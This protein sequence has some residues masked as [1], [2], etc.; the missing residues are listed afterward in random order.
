MPP[1]RIDVHHH[2][3]PPPYVEAVGE[4]AIGAL[5]V[6]GRAPQWTPQASVEAMDRNGIATAVTSMSAPAFG[7]G[8]GARKLARQCNDYAAA[9]RRDHPGRFGV[10]ATLPLPDI[11][12]SLAEI[13]Y[14]FDELKADGIGLLTN[15]DGLYPGDPAIAPVFEELDRRGAVVFFHPAAAEPCNCLCGMPAAT[16]DFPFD[17]TRAVA[18]LLL[19]GTFARH[20]NI[21]FVFSHAGGTVPFLAGRL[22]RLERRP[23]YRPQLPDGVMAELKR[24]YFDTALSANRFAFA[25]LLQLTTVEQVLFGSDYPFAPEDTMTATVAGLAGLGL[26]TAELAAIERDNALRLLPGL[27]AA[28][29]APALSLPPLAGGGAG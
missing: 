18:S 27:A 12:G 10:F 11:D 21:R 3:L 23:E 2:I 26:T 16:L 20:R 6:S 8:A 25:A 28:G 1:H 5:L 24:L 17:T 14:A 13:A 29:E 19:N 22:A 9:M 15:Y 4:A 7:R